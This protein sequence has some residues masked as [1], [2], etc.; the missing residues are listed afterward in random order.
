PV[1]LSDVASVYDGQEN[2][3]NMGVAN[4]KPAVLIS[5]T[6]Q[7]GSNVIQVVDQ[8]KKI[9]PDLQT[10]LPPSIDPIL[11][12]QDHTVSIR[13][14]VRDVE[15][16]LM[17]STYLV[18]LVVFFFLRN[19]P[20]T[21]VPAV[22]VPLA[23]L[24]TFSLMY[25]AGYSLNNFSLMALIISTGFVVDNAIVVLENVTRHLEEGRPRLEAALVGTGEVAFT[26]ISMSLSL[27]AVFLPILF[28]P[29]IVGKIFHEFAMVL[30]IAIFVS[31][32]V[33]L[34]VT[35][36]MCA[37][38][39]FADPEKESGMMRVARRAFEAS[40]EFYRHTLAW[41]LNNP[42][43]VMVTLLVAI[44]LN[45]YLY[46][47]VPSGFFPQTDEG[48]LN[49]S[50]RGDQ[51]ASFDS[52]KPKFME[53]M[54][55]IRKDPAVQ[56]VAG[57]MQNNGGNLFVTL[58]PPAERNHVTSDE[59]RDRLMP[60]FAGIA[61]AR[62]FINSVS[63]TGVRVGGRQG[64]GNYQYTVQADTLD[65]LKEWVPKIQTA[66]MNVPEI[67]SVD[68]D[69]QPGGLEMELKIDRQTAA[70]MGLATNL[71]TGPLQHLFSEGPVSTI[72]KAQNQYRVIME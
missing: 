22:S 16:T 25:A 7:P 53:F 1:R 30:T 20:A 44:G 67:E 9:L 35:P 19:L 3:R 32:I 58:K 36:M 29:G 68:P 4:G 47:I 34:T 43:T 37:Y 49:G 57:Y 2:V 33:S 56:T 66:L 28:F 55:I 54:S 11:V 23:L 5:I 27:V 72:Y 21:A 50:I 45:V 24:G 70:R 14:S 51:T 42:K 31:L 60:Q 61:G 64:T 62:A 10:L 39:S 8:I 63:S 15:I 17:L 59:V 41:S 26:V 13:T 46:T 6:Q 12:V 38:I 48:R 18:V 65:D 40:L 69:Q 52:M 71:I